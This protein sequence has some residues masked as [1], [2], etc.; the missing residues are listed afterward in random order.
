MIVCERI[1]V[2]FLLYRRNQRTT[3]CSKKSPKDKTPRQVAS[4]GVFLERETGVEAATY[5]AG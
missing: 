2:I 4:E 1:D 5:F 3:A